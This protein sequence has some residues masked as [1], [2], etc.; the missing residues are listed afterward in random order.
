MLSAGRLT[1]TGLAQALTIDP[2]SGYYYNQEVLP[3]DLF[4]DDAAIEGSFAGAD[5]P[6]MTIEAQ[7]VP[8]IAPQ[9]T[10]GSITLEP[11]QDFTLRWTPE[12]AGRVRV[13][14]NSNNQ[15]HGMPYLGIIRCD[16]PD[17]DGEVVIPASL[18][19]QFP[20]TYAWT[21][22]AGTDCPPSTIRR[23]TRGVAPVGDDEVVELTVA[24]QWSF[25]VEH[26]P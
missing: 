14:L 2:Q 5:L 20:E 23:Y 6:A 12:G 18:H 8:P 7:G 16:V 21:A 17:A 11:G 13:T 25:G 3:V 15:G 22:C 9:I 19:D 4:A 24:S 10:N 26:H 1:V